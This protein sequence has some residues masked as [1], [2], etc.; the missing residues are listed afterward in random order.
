MGRKELDPRRSV[1][2]RSPVADRGL[3]H[4]RPEGVVIRPPHFAQRPLEDRAHGTWEPWVGLTGATGSR[5]NG[6]DRGWRELRARSGVVV[7][8]T[9]M[10]RVKVEGA[11]LFCEL[12]GEEGDPIVLIHGSW[13]DHRT[14][15]LLT[16]LLLGS[17]RPLTY[18][19]RGHGQSDG[20]PR[21]S[22]L[23][24]DARDLA[25][26][27]VATDH[28]PAH[29]VGHSYGGNVA[30]RLA[31]ERPEL[32]RSVV[33]HEPALL[34]LLEEDPTSQQEAGRLRE[35]IAH[36]ISLIDRG[37][38]EDAA[39]EFVNAF[40]QD[41]EAWERMSLEWK[42]TFV[43]NAPR[44]KEEFSDPATDRPDLASLSEFMSPILFTEGALSPPF[45]HRSA[46]ALREHLRNAYVMRLPDVGHYPHVS[47]PALYVA[48]LHRF[49]VE[50]DV[51]AM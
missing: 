24:T 34:G 5:A 2:A 21:P 47:H 31:A 33:V 3:A 28:Y 20:L 46:E 13:V 43:E 10:P 23:S 6:L 40:A 29:V 50:R 48:V 4:Q 25:E 36:L 22:P 37:R 41:P 39:R 51:P 26:L 12:Q 11:E 16:P 14:W 18:D 44:W 17:M 45:L 9:V 42:R 27:L 1:V 35:G 15:A 7:P 49:L 8:S 19:R 38:S 32:V 30:L